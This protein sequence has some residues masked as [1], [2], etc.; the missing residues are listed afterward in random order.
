MFSFIA[1][2]AGKLWVKTAYTIRLQ[3]DAD[4]TERF[5]T[6]LVSLCLAKASEKEELETFL[7]DPRLSFCFLLYLTNITN[8]R[9]G[10]LNQILFKIIT[11]RQKR[12]N[13]MLIF[14]LPKMDLS[15]QNKIVG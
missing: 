11:L 4:N 10:D 12:M 5:S 3:L 9:I 7:I 15:T 8:L 1:W 2:N 6:C 14:Y 13:S